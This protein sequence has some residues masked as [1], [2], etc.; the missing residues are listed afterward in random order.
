MGAGLAHLLI[1]NLNINR[2]EIFTKH[3]TIDTTNS[4]PL[5]KARKICSY[6]EVLNLTNWQN[7]DLI[8]QIVTVPCVM[9]PNGYALGDKNINNYKVTVNCSQNDLNGVKIE[10]FTIY[11]NKEEEIYKID[12]FKE[13]C[14][15]GLSSEETENS[16]NNVENKE[17]QEYF[18]DFNLDLTSEIII[19]HG[20]EIF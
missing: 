15:Q 5:E 19:S 10:N 3:K 11:G 7:D 4:D 6:D 1:F 2:R 9:D 16:K 12:D 20:I 17:W 14:F 13:I 18:D 8:I